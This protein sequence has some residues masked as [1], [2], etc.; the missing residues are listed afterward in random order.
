[1]AWHAAT[2]LYS[3]LLIYRH[4]QILNFNV[5]ES[6]DLQ[7]PRVRSFTTF[8]SSSQAAR[9][10]LHLRHDFDMPKLSHVQM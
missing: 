9:I 5:G 8:L 3:G 4:I 7:I 2:Y 1:M 10:A 6:I